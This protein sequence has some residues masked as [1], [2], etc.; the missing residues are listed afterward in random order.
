MLWSA[1]QV[2]PQGAGLFPCGGKGIGG[3]GFGEGLEGRTSQPGGRS[4]AAILTRFEF[5]APLHQLADVRHDPI[6]F[7][8]R[9]KGN[10]APLQVSERDSTPG[11]PPIEIRSATQRAR[12]VESE[13]EKSWVEIRPRPDPEAVGLV[14]G[15]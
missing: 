6:L 1:D 3:L 7:G 15:R 4:V 8:E 5:I 14:E 9:W 13:D 10:G 11:V 12:G 2:G